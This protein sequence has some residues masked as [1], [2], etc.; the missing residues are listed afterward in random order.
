[1]IY[2][3]QKGISLVELM[4]AMVLGLLVIAAV[5][6]VFV[7]GQTTDRNM[8]VRQQLVQQARSIEGRLENMLRE[9]GFRANAQDDPWFTFGQ[10]AAANGC[11]AMAPGIVVARSNAGGI[12]FRKEFAAGDK[13]CFGAPVD[14]ALV[15]TTV[16]QR[17]EFDAADNELQCAVGAGALTRI[18]SMVGGFQVRYGIKPTGQN[19]GLSYFVEQPQVDANGG[20]LAR[21]GAIRIDLLM[22]STEDVFDTVTT[23]FFPLDDPAATNLADDRMYLSRSLI[24]G[25]R[26]KT[27]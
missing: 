19:R 9:A 24:V 17:L 20:E 22:R 6:R 10:Q 2:R 1:M 18:A 27:I 14:A 7:S 5:S 8:S 16:T 26:N 3:Q 25:L 13:T 12:C 11:P 23:V 15:G 21:L 4:I